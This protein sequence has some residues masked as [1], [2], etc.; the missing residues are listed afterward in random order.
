[1]SQSVS[2]EEIARILQAVVIGAAFVLAVGSRFEA[3]LPGGVST[4]TA[5][6]VSFAVA[7]VA[8]AVAEYFR[9]DRLLSALSLA[10]GVMF[11]LI[12]VGPEQG[13]LAA[14]GGLFLVSGLFVATFIYRDQGDGIRERA[15][16][17]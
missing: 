4:V 13:Q 12:G 15:N 14:V 2:T 10:G 5:G 16:G 17:K 11:T 7:F 6:L 9:G 8:A 3:T 1:M